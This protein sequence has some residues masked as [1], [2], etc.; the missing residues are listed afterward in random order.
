MHH[1]DEKRKEIFE[2]YGDGESAAVLASAF[3][4]SPQRVHQIILQET[5]QE[6]L[7]KLPA[8]ALSMRTL[9]ALLHN[10]VVA[11]ELSEINPEW[12]VRNFDR[13]DLRGIRNLGEMGQKEVISWVEAHGLKLCDREIVWSRSTDNRDVARRLGCLEP[14]QISA[15]SAICNR[16]ESRTPH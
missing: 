3:N 10:P 13:L 5:A 8:G 1:G 12:L 4:I 16:L 14:S 15:P 11:V 6:M 7:S 2:R 9:K